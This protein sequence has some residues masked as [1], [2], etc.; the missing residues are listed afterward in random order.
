VWAVG[1]QGVAAYFACVAAVAVDW[2][3]RAA[4][5]SCL[6]WCGGRADSIHTVTP[7]RTKQS[8]LCRVWRG[9]VN[10]LAEYLTKSE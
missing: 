6:V 7:D 5:L 10:Y 1:P 3:A 8:C 2:Q 9:G 4:R